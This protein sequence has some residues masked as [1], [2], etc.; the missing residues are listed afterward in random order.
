MLGHYELGPQKLLI[1]LLLITSKRGYSM[2]GV[3][4]FSLFVSVVYSLP[5]KPHPAFTPCDAVAKRGSPYTC[6]THTVLTD[7]GFLL[8]AYRVSSSKFENSTLPPVLLQH[9]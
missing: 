8:R 3:L 9:G 2:I 1:I 5:S 4:T 6:T 7:D